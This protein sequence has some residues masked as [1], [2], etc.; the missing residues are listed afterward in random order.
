MRAL[1]LINGKLSD[2]YARV[3]DYGHEFMSYNPD[4]TI[5][6]SV[7]VNSDQTT[8]FIEYTFALKQLKRA[9]EGDLVG[10]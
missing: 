2:H 4:S 8:T 3:W 5:R 9:G 1:S 6:I 7:T 10:Y